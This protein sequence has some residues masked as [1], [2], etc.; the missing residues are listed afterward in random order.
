MS[1]LLSSGEPVPVRL[2]NTIRADRHGL[3]DDLRTVDDLRE[4]L[5]LVAGVEGWGPG[6]VE[7]SDLERFRRLR[8]A[9]RRLAAFRTGDD[10]PAAI[11]SAQDLEAAVAEVNDAAAQAPTW[12]TLA[13]REG[14]LHR[15][16]SVEAGVVAQCLSSI[17][18]QAVD[19]LGDPES[20]PLRAC[21]APAC[22][23]YFVKDH[24]RREWCSA[25]CGNRAR[26]ARHYARRR[27]G[28][29]NG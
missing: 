24:P 22:V 11:T 8:D 26:A 12:P 9:L 15:L 29:A 14:R 27:Q 25:G 18:A 16:P 19:L 23:L 5:A 4:W 6:S 17:A 1:A 20:S 13:L 2:M 7:E 21:R 28:R 3:R 10:R